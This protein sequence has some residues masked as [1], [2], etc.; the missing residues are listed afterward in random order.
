MP[1]S[2]LTRR[3]R[4]PSIDPTRGMA[5]HGGGP[6]SGKDPVQG[7]PLGRLRRP[8]VPKN[9]GS[10]RCGH[11]RS[12]AGGVCHGVAVPCRSGRDV[13]PSRPTRRHAISSTRSHLAPGRPSCATSELKRRSTGSTAGAYPVTSG[14]SDKDFTWRRHRPGGR[15]EAGARPLDAGP[16]CPARPRRPARAGPRSRSAG[17]W[18][19]RRGRPGPPGH[20]RRPAH[21]PAGAV[22]RV[23]LAA[24][25]PSACFRSSARA[26]SSQV[27]SLSDRPK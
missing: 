17:G 26:V 1:T 20:G 11:V 25:R 23:G 2:G 10:R 16:G 6:F 12:S 13:G 19:G 3:D 14:R 18:P 5:R 8:L 21:H 15:T 9:V 7:R 22:G 27:K 24:Q 4:G